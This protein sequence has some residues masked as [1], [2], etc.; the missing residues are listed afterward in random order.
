[1][2]ATSHIRRYTPA[3]KISKPVKYACPDIR[4]PL[5]LLV[6]RNSERLAGK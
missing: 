6:I 1:M 5:T 2:R 3:E 4:L